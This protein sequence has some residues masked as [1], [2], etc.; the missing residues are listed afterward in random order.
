MKYILRHDKTTIDKNY[1]KMNPEQAIEMQIKMHKKL[2]LEG[3]TSKVKKDSMYSLNTF[4]DPDTT[5]VEVTII[6]S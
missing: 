3:T 1:L 2:S 6:K 4:L 5:S